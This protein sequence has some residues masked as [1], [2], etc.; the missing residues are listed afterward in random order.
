MLEGTSAAHRK[1]NERTREPHL[2]EEPSTLTVPPS[3]HLALR[4]DRHA[5]VRFHVSF[6]V[7]WAPSSLND[8]HNAAG[9]Q[10]K[11]TCSHATLKQQRKPLRGTTST[12]L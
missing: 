9:F 2:L 7:S 4:M 5:R 11:N 8:D 3:E 10:S 12:D 6:H 1:R